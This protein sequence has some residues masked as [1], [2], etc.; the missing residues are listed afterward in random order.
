MHSKD[1]IHHDHAPQDTDPVADA[2][3][4]DALSLLVAYIGGGVP[5]TTGT[6]GT[7]GAAQRYDAEQVKKSDVTIENAALASFMQTDIFEKLSRDKMAVAALASP[8]HRA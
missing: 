8:G 2:R 1:R 6:Q 7:I 3:V 4:T 5:A